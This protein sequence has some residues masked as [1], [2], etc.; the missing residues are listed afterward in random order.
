[1]LVSIFVG[2]G[3]SATA[4]NFPA[5]FQAAAL[6]QEGGEYRTNFTQSFPLNADGRFS[7]DN[8][9]GQI[10]IQGWSS[11]IVAF[12]AAV[13]GKTPESVEAIRIKV[14][15]NPNHADVH[16]ETSNGNGGFQSLWDLIKHG[17]RDNATVD[18]TVHV[19]ERAHL[20]GVSSVN[21]QIDIDGVAGDITA[22]T[23]NGETQ[24]K[25]ACANLKLNT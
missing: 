10:E 15:T 9:N 8:I 12:T 7:I 21:G 1:V 4:A 22:S 20:A 2:A 11:N 13:H 19:P 18:Y 6:R 3:A 25:G 16:T 14:N 24:I 23:V 5:Q 17:L